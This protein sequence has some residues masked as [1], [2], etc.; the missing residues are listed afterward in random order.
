DPPSLREQRERV[1]ARS[2]ALEPARPTGA[3]GRLIPQRPKLT[4]IARGRVQPGQI[5]LLA[6]FNEGE[7]TALDLVVT[8]AAIPAHGHVALDRC[9]IPRGQLAFE[10]QQELVFVRVLVAA[11]FLMLKPGIHDD[12]PLSNSRERLRV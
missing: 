12:A 9:G 7:N 6:I 1:K 11:E 10:C 2:D 3:G 4:K 8:G 5:N